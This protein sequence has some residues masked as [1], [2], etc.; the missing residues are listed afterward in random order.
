MEDTNWTFPGHALD[1]RS[2]QCRAIEKG[3]L[4]DPPIRGEICR[5]MEGGADAFEER[6]RRIGKTTSL[7]TE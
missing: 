3:S 2:G 4:Q 7:T 5:V 6:Y 1:F